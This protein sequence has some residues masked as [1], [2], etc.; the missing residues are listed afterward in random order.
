[1]VAMPSG[2]CIYNYHY[3][4]VAKTFLISISVFLLCPGRTHAVEPTDASAP[5]VKKVEPPNWWVGL[6]QDVVVLLSGQNLQGADAACD[7][8]GV[9]AGRTQASL[10]GDYLFVWLKFSAQL[11]SGTAA[12]QISTANGRTSF[13]FPIASRKP[14]AGRNQ[15][16]ALDDVIYPARPVCHR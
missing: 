13:P 14:I 2:L 7:L 6:T 4:S 1:M 9:T 10:N 3:H 15:G 16:L 8:A 11:K 5:I 12:C